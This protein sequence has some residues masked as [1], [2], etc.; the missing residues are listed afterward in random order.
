MNII[1]ENQR[2]VSAANADTA[3]FARVI[4]E[5]GVKNFLDMGTGTGYIAIYLAK[6]GIP[7]AACDLSAA[8]V[9]L[10]RKNVRRNGV[11]VPVYQSDMFSNLKGTFESVGF[12]V[13]FSLGCKAFLP[14]GLK[15]ALR[16]VSWIND[17]LVWHIPPAIL[18][19]RETMISRFLRESVPFLDKS[20]RIFLLL[21]RPEIEFV[22]REGSRFGFEFSPREA[23]ELGPRNM[24]V[25]QLRR[26]TQ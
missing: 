17:Y 18:A 7:V 23:V 10:A 6:H 12:N 19:Q 14:E 21:Y 16:R 15:A 24:V 22:A 1:L 11:T 20:G 8:A 5:A 3:V 4:R 25:A 2:S 13:P 26:G 9:D